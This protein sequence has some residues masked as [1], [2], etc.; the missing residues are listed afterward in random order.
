MVGE[1]EGRVLVTSAAGSTG[2][3][4]AGGWREDPRQDP[5]GRVPLTR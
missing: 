4:R 1:A 2:T 5:P 3:G